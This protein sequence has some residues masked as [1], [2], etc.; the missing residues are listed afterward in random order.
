EL[1]IGGDGLGRGYRKRPDLTAEKFIP[2][3]FAK[4]QGERL[5]RTGDLARFR[6]NGTI[7]VLGRLDHQVKVRGY[8]IELGEIESALSSHAMVQ[9]CVVT[10]TPD[11]TGEQRLIGYFVPDLQ[12]LPTQGGG[13]FE[14]HTEQIAQ[15]QSVWDE[16][17]SEDDSVRDP[18][19]NISGWKDSYTGLPIPAEQMR[20]WVENTVAHIL[21]LQ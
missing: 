11:T 9:Q 5:Y 4:R 19:F 16:A 17:Y 3:P 18:T 10:A 6:D 2:S 21:S 12:A 1:Y 15:W 13:L 8:R 20:D 14:W 7:E